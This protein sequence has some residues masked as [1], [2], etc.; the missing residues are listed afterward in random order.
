M[1]PQVT[2]EPGVVVRLPW[3][4]ETDPGPRLCATCPLRFED[5]DGTQRGGDVVCFGGKLMQ[6]R[7]FSLSTHLEVYATRRWVVWIVLFCAGAV[8]MAACVLAGWVGIAMMRA[9]LR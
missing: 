9:V 6:L 3:S 5:M 7:G 4:A 8:L 2:E 1:V